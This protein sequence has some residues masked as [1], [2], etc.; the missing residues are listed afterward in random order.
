MPGIRMVFD[1][2]YADDG[3]EFA[4]NSSD[5]YSLFKVN[6]I[7]PP[8]RIDLSFLARRLHE[9]EHF[10]KTHKGRS[11]IP[12]AEHDGIFQFHRAVV[13]AFTLALEHAKGNVSE[14]VWYVDKVTW[15]QEHHY[16]T[17]HTAGDEF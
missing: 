5:H 10:E 11:D 6:F 4:E 12:K 9:L 1:V 7:V 17:R 3:S 8:S 13:R 2:V 14:H 16:Y 15:Q